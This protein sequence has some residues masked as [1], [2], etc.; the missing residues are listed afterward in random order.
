MELNSFRRTV[1]I[2][3]GPLM[4]G[5]AGR[6][7]DV[8]DV[9]MGPSV[10]ELWIHIENAALGF[11]VYWDRQAVGYAAYPASQREQWRSWGIGPVEVAWWL[12][13]PEKVHGNKSDDI[14]AMLKHIATIEE[15]ARDLERWQDVRHRRLAL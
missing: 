7:Y 13:E 4:E 2:V 1:D 8:V 14:P 5:L 12:D 3:T 15:L 6:R 10:H 11:C 9:V